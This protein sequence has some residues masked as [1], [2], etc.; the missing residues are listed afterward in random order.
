MLNE[1]C[2][3]GGRQRQNYFRYPI[4]SQDRHRITRRL[5]FVPAQFFCAVCGEPYQVKYSMPERESIT[6]VLSALLYC[7]CRAEAGKGVISSVLHA[8][9][10]ADVPIKIKLLIIEDNKMVQI[11]QQS[12]FQALGYEVDLADTAQGGLDKLNR[13]PYALLIIDLSLPDQSGID[14]TRTLRAQ[15]KY[16]TLPIIGLSANM[17][18]AC[19]QE[20]LAAGMQEALQK[21]LNQSTAKDMLQKY[22]S[23]F[24]TT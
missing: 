21:P 17:N 13:N 5:G 6:D 14:L 10:A 20:C 9:D 3:R 18:K 2:N 12:L 1:Q 23:G 4:S 7:V 11:A 16:D 15:A 22:A 19:K 24:S 8:L